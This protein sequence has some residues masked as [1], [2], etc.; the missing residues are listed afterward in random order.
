MDGTRL[1]MMMLL[2]VVV[3]VQW[4]RGKMQLEKAEMMLAS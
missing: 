1:N 2:Q 4:N 3:V